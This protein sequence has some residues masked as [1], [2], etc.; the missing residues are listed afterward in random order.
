M[1][2]EVLRRDL[3][4]VINRAAYGIEPVLI[5]RRGRKIAALISLDDFALLVRMQQQRDR[6]R[7]DALDC[8]WVPE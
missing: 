6:M 5:T 4:Q 8:G 2:T 7:A 3:S 1:S